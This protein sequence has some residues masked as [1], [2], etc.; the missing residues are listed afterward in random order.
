MP[1]CIV[2]KGRPVDTNFLNVSG[3]G[4]IISLAPKFFKMIKK[5]DK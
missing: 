4:K 1:L 3:N 5:K 2:E